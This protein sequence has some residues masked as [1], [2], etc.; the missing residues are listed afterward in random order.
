MLCA[1]HNTIRIFSD[2]HKMVL[3]KA[4][5]EAIAPLRERLGKLRADEW[6]KANIIMQDIVSISGRK[7]KIGGQICARVCRGCGYFGHSKEYC[8]KRVER[9]Q[10]EMEAEMRAEERRKERLRER[11]LRVKTGRTQADI[12]DDMGLPWYRDEYVGPLV[13]SPGRDGGEGRWVCVNGE[14]TEKAALL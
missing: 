6:Q 11:E 9:E 14:L 5:R 1:S 4:K 8:P 3:S 7:S 13:L 12:L 10:R 2:T